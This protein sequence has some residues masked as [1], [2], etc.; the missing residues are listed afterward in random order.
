MLNKIKR[1]KN[2]LIIVFVLVYCALFFVFFGSNKI[3]QNHAYDNY[4]FAANGSGNVSGFA[5]G[6]NYGWVS[7]NSRDCDINDD[8]SFGDVTAPVGCPASSPPSANGYSVNK[9]YS[10]GQLSGFAWSENLGWVY[11]GP[12]DAEIATSTSAPD[13]TLGWAKMNTV[14]GAISGW[15]KVLSLGNDG[16]IKLKKEAGDTLSSSYG[17][18][19]TTTGDFSGFA[20]NGNA[21]SSLGLGWLSFNSKDCDINGNGSFVGEVGAPVGCPTT[22][23]AFAYKVAVINTPPTVASAS[24]TSRWTN[25][26]ACDANS[27]LRQ[28][29]NW[30]YNDAE[31]DIGTAYQIVVTNTSSVEILRTPVCDSSKVGI[32][33]CTMA[34]TCLNNINTCTYTLN[35]TVAP[36]LSYGKAYNWTVQVW[37]GTASSSVVSAP[38]FGSPPSAF[39]TF[40]HEFPEP[41]F[42]WSPS[43]P[44]KGQVVTFSPTGSN[45]YAGTSTV[46]AATG[47]NALWNWSFASGNPLTS[48][49]M[50]A[51]T[52]YSIATTSIVTLTLTDKQT[53]SYSCS[54]STPASGGGGGGGDGGALIIKQTSPK[55]IEQKPK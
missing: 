46:Q 22:G 23:T 6:E 2:L 51:T 38:S 27:A 44:S 52:T 17:V 43:S 41:V 32:G 54:T 19:A 39:T 15:A 37:S 21:S 42:T 30:H 28:Q 55:W 5:W 35:T 50:N 7:F 10:T 34:L 36:L 4:V 45:V 49:I 40:T 25:T 53:P 33:S 20:W 26:D 29:L 14:T 3:G 31:T 18:N 12:D 13:P 48:N 9:D 47:A 11:F 16:W 8:G 1:Y 24:M